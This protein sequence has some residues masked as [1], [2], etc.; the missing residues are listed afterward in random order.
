MILDDLLKIDFTGKDVLILGKPGAGKTWVS[1]I[2]A[3]KNPLVPNHLIIST[4]DY[5]KCHPE[6]EGRID[7]IVEDASFNIN[8]IIE[9]CLGYLLLLEGAKRKCYKPDYVIEVEI[10]AGKQR[11]IYLKERDTSKIQYLKRFQLKCIAILDEYYKLVPESEMP[12]WLT[13]KNEW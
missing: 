5:L 3:Q 11:E 8:T 7:A 10:S 13:L 1:N 2:L 4:D 9:G 6:E 12:I